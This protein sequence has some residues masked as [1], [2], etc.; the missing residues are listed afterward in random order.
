MKNKKGSANTPPQPKR[1]HTTGVV[2][3]SATREPSR[4]EEAYRNFAK[5]TVTTK[6]GKQQEVL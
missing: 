5:V 3:S 6:D 2:Y 1:F 4:E